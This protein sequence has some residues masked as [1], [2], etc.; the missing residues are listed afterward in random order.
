MNRSSIL[1]VTGLLVW[2]AASGFTV[3]AQD[4][5]EDSPRPEQE[6]ASHKKKSEPPDRF[7]PSEEVSADQEV[8]FP[9]DI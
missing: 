6:Q 4:A 7:I 9:A 5:D 3:I 1:A 2:L 8:D